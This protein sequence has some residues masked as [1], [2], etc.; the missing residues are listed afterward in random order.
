MTDGIAHDRLEKLQALRASGKDPF[1][2]R[3]PRG[4]PIGELLVDF[5]ARIG[6][7]VTICGRLSQI[8]DFGKLRFSHLEDRTGCLQIGFQRDR[9]AGF[10]PDRKLIEGNDLVSIRGE[11]GLTQKG[12]PTLWADEVTLAGKALRAAPEK[13]HGLTDTEQRYRMRYVDLFA[14]RDVRQTFMLRSLLVR[15]V[16]RYFDSLGYLEVETPIL[17]PIFGGAAARPF[18]THHNTLDMPL[19][20]RIAPELYLKRLIVGGLERVYEIGRVFRNEGISTRHNPEFTML[21]S[22]EAWADYHDIMA[23]VEGLFAH[24]VEHVLGGNGLVTFREHQYDLRPPFQK[25]RYLELFATNNPGVDW[26]DHPS[27]VARAR[28]LGLKVDGIEPAKLANDVFEAT[29]EDKL[30]G[31]VFV[32]DY[33]VAISPLA[34]R[35]AGDPRVTERFELFVAGMELGNAF[36]ELNDPIDQ[37][38]RFEAQLEH[39]DDETPGEVDLDYVTALEYGMPPAGGLGIGIDRLAMLLTGSTSIRDV[40]LFP[41]LRR[42]DPVPGEPT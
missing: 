34:K 42:I 27:C 35:L 3:C 2:A 16:R 31:P 15:E 8:R 41:L 9:L 37:Q 24:L 19:F 40:V 12:E 7:Q 1:P 6:Q 14:N 30:T 38:Q 13:W 28:E 5:A 22:Y 11:L 10:W 4:Q 32:Y 21:E 26:F 39:K 20:L 23:R 17:Q 29:C 18:Q 33:P 25:V 36:S